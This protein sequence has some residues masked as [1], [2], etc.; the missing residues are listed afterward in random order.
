VFTARYG[1]IKEDEVYET[2]NKYW[3]IQKRQQH[4]DNMPIKFQ[5]KDRR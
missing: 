4:I 5:D 3:G 2:C 1:P